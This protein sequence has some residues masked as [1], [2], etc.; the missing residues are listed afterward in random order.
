M[1]KNALIIL[2]M[3]LFLIS[4]INAAPPSQQTTFV[5]VGI[6]LESPMVESIKI[7][8][9]FKF[10]IHAHNASNGRLLTNTTT[11]C[12]IHIYNKTGS[13]IIEAPMTFD[14]NRVDFTYTALGSTFSKTGT[15]PVLYYCNTS[16]IGGFLEH[17]LEVT[18]TGVVLTTQKSLMYVAL[19][20]FFSIAFLFS[21]NRLF[22]VPNGQ[23]LII[24]AVL[25]YFLSL[26][27]IFLVW[28]LLE[29]YVYDLQWLT[30]LFSILFI[31][32]LILMFPFI[33]GL[34]VYLF[35]DIFNEKNMRGLTAMGYSREEARSHRR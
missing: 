21:L 9:P 27:T 35:L 34:F 16:S 6:Q 25:S 12:L 18:T 33:I 2:L 14:S 3:G 8:E 1:R 4:F 26:I 20:L 15:Y 31:I 13:H 17:T 22:K 19:L 30:S 32:D 7:N 10:H 11:S 5:S 23:W 29:N 24:F 28:T